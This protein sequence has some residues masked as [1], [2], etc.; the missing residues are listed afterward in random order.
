MVRA[1]WDGIA[2]SLAF[3]HAMEPVL[4]VELT[5]NWE[6]GMWQQQPR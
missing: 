3:L 4:T 6:E 1:V 5:D 2:G